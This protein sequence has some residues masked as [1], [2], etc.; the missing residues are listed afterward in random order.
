MCRGSETQLQVGEI[1]IDSIT[2]TTSYCYNITSLQFKSVDL[3]NLKTDFKI[4]SVWIWVFNWHFHP[5]E[6]VSRWRDP[7]LQVR[8]NDSD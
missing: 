1:Y 8:E 5:H 4:Y 7:Q 2:L 6:V 3:F